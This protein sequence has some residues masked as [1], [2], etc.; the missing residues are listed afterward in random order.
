MMHNN[1]FH[2]HHSASSLHPVHVAAVPQTYIY[3]SQLCSNLSG[4]FN[5]GVRHRS[6]AM[7]AEHL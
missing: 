4:G 7:E 1:Q 5:G 2:L 3:N 6:S